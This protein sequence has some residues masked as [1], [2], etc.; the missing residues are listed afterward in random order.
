MI[1]QFIIYLE[2]V[3]KYSEHTAISYKND[4]QQL[5]DFLS[6]NYELKD[7]SKCNH[8]MIRTWVVHMS[9]E[10]ITPRSINRKLSTLNTFFKYA[11]RN[12]LATK[13]PLKKVVAPKVGKRLPSYVMAHDMPKVL[14][15]E[16]SENDYTKA[17]NE[18]IIFMLYI[19]GMR[20]SE[21]LNLK[22]S[23]INMQRKDIRVIGKGKKE[24]IIPISIDAIQK[25]KS[26]INIRQE[27][28][29]AIP[30]EDNYFLLS[31]RGKQ[32]NPR[33]LYAIVN[34]QLQGA[35]S[36]EKKSPHVL[37]HSFATH[38]L[39]EG[40]D[41]NVIKEILGHA[42]LAATQVYTHNSIERLKDIYKTFHPKA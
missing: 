40:A 36:A 27:H 26:Y 39:N 13:N 25:I 5:S 20:R 9:K 17:R 31:G 22:I 41:I 3:K 1:D 15:V 7:I 12:G 33:S 8:M 14:R 10:G 28:F 38:L 30:I 23:D 2:K 6:I 29:E 32:M 16:V 37:R 24:R 34:R 42:N 35:N 11:I 18:V 19:T 4:L 21:L